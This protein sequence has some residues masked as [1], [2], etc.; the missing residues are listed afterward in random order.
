MKIVIDI[1]KEAH[2]WPGQE[3][4]I[5]VLVKRDAGSSL[6]VVPK[7]PE[8]LSEDEAIDVATSIIKRFYRETKG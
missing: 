1:T 2:K 7:N 8:W 6:M 4:Q 5:S 3:D